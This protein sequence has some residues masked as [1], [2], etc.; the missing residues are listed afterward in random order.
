MY[1][2]IKTSLVQIESF[3]LYITTYKK[4]QFVIITSEGKRKLFIVLFKRN[5][6][7]LSTKLILV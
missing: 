4:F 3:I 5:C 2:Y 7:Y 1:M 6:Q